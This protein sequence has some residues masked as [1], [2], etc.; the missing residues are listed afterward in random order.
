[1]REY[2]LF[3][4]NKHYRKLTY[5]KPYNLYM[6]LSGIRK[7]NIKDIRSAYSLYDS[8]IE[9]INKNKVISSLNKIKNSLN[10]TMVNNIYHYN[11]Y[12][13]NET[14]KIIIHK[15][16]IKVI[17]NK[18]DSYIFKLLYKVDDLFLVDFI[19]MKYFWLS[20]IENKEMV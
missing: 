15:S 2:Y 16:Y 7:S 14:T 10:L 13:L 19:N 18:E 8:I 17:T 6:I 9:L 20:N 12:Y 11:N 1:M 5:D 3:K 4:I